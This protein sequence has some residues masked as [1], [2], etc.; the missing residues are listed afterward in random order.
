MT[1]LK[2]AFVKIYKKQLFERLNLYRNFDSISQTFADF[3]HEN[4][5]FEKKN[6]RS[7]I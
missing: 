5:F 3:H 4:V 2:E 7:E 6:Q 1:N